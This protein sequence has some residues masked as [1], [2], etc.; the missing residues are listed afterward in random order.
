MCVHDV[1]DRVGGVGVDVVLRVFGGDVCGCMELVF[2][3]G[4]S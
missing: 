1:G 3:K 4:W 2:G